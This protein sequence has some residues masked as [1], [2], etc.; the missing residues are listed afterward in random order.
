M[1]DG[2]FD[3]VADP[4][5]Q[6]NYNPQEMARM[7]ASAAGSI[8]HSARKRPKMSQIVR[9]LEGE[10]SLD[11]LN[12]GVKPGHSSIYSLD[13]SSDY[14]QSIYNADMKKFRQIALTSAEFPSSEYGTS[15]T[16]S[17]EMTP[18]GHQKLK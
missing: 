6:G 11:D 5:L 13:G 2:N 17:R 10:V 4:R 15:S 16:D 7:V 18:S 3:E 1:E 8:R 12:E 14:T 9:A